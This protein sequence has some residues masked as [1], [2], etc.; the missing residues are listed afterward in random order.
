MRV[1]ICTLKV[2]V[3]HRWRFR[4]RRRLET[5]GG[6]R[7][8]LIDP[9]RAEKTQLSQLSSRLSSSTS[10]NTPPLRYTLLRYFDGGR[11]GR[12]PR[13]AHV[14]GSARGVPFVNLA[15]RSFRNVLVVAPSSSSFI[16][17]SG[18]L[19]EFVM[20]RETVS[21]GPSDLPTRY[22]LSLPSSSSPSSSSRHSKKTIISRD[23]R[24]RSIDEEKNHHESGSRRR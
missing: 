14:D 20:W 11:H 15:S 2:H 19:K 21:L 13:S 16:P 9:Q 22:P 17:R 3:S 24:G 1:P 8:V 5:R 23:A 6:I 10:P 18:V 12:R 7:R 4:R